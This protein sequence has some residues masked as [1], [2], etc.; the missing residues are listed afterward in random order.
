MLTNEDDEVKV[1]GRS[2]CH[3]E[4]S[5]SS[6]FVFREYEV[7]YASFAIHVAF[8]ATNRVTVACEERALPTTPRSNLR[9]SFPILLARILHQAA[10]PT[11]PAFSVSQDATVY[12]SVT[13]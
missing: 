2:D 10:G 1:D 4:S 12:F 3:C 9:T 7:L 11:D 8:L 6:V 13:F 5:Q